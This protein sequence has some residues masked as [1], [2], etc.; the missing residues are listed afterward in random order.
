MSITQISV[1]HNCVSFSRSHL[2]TFYVSPLPNLSL[3]PK[4]LGFSLSHPNL[5]TLSLNS[6]LL[7]NQ[8][9]FALVHMS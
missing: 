8:S 7:A 1:A 5:P 6:A 2:S 3:S 4:L 9:H